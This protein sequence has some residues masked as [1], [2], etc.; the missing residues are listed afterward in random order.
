MKIKTQKGF[1]EPYDMQRIV[2]SLESDV[3]FA[4]TQGVL[5]DLDGSHIRRIARRVTTKLDKM[6]YEDND[7]IS[8]DTIRGLTVSELMADGEDQVANVVGL[9]GLHPKRIFEIINGAADND[10]ANLQHNPETTHKIIAD[11]VSKKYYLGQ[12]PREM[13]RLHLAGDLHIHDLEYFG[14]RLFCQDW[15]LRYFFYYGLM[16]DGEGTRASVSGPAKNPEVAIL[17]AVKA[18]SAAQT[19]FA[20]GQGFYNFLTF[21]APYLEGLSY[22]EIYQL[23]QMFVYEMTQMMVARG[24]QVVFSSVQLTPGVPV[25][26]RDK[27]AVFKGKVWSDRTYGEFE[28]EVRLAFKALMEVMIAGDYWG[29]PFNFPKPEIAIEPEFIDPA[30][31]ED[32]PAIDWRERSTVGLDCLPSYR[33]LYGLAFELTAKFGTPYFDNMIPAYRGHSKGGVACY[34]SIPGD[35]LVATKSIDGIKLEH[36]EDVSDNDMLLT[37]TGFET[38]ESMLKYE[39]DRDILQL[40]LLNGRLI[41]CTPEHEMPVVRNGESIRL[42]ACDI[43]KGD[44]LKVF[45]SLPNTGGLPRH[46]KSILGDNHD[47]KLAYF[48][49]LYTA[50]GNILIRDSKIGG[51]RVQ[52][53]F[54]EENLAQ[55]TEKLIRDLFGWNVRTHHIGGNE[56]RVLAYGKA[57][58]EYLH[59]VLH[60]AEKTGKEG[61]IPDHIFV[62]RDELKW[63]F[64]Q[65]YM[66][67]DGSLGTTENGHGKKYWRYSIETVSRE[68]AEGFLLLTASLGHN[69]SLIDIKTRPNIQLDL[70]READLRKV[71][72][73][74]QGDFDGLLPVSSIST[75]NYTGYVYDPI[76]VENHDFVLGTGL[77]SGNCCAYN[78]QVDPLTDP[79]FADKMQFKNGAH[80]SM[81]SSQVVTLNVPRAA[82]YASEGLT[83][84]SR[85]L[86]FINRLKSLMAE[87]CKVFR[88]KKSLLAPLIAGGRVPFATQR[89]KDPVTGEK[90]TPAADLDAMVWTIGIV[91]MNEAIEVICGK[92]L[93]EDD[94]AVDISRRVMTELK[95]YCYELTAE[96]GFKI[97]LARTPAETVAQRFAVLDLTDDAYHDQ[98]IRVVKGDVTAAIDQFCSGSRDLPIYYTN[99]CMLPSDCDNIY[100]RLTTESKFFPLVDGGN[101]FHIWLGEANTDP[102]ALMDF[103][104][105]VATKTDIG[106]FAFTKDLTVCRTCGTSQCGLH[107][108]CGRCHSDAVDYISRITGYLSSVSGWNAAKRQELEDRR[109]VSI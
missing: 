4:K 99:G 56:Y 87:A 34:Q 100:Q 27:P 92:Q 22:P 60:L 24:G 6:L 17:H 57:L 67:G 38:F 97:A 21:L 58:C 14:T 29:K 63:A 43:Q 25:L 30:T 36:I 106:Y 105:R 8:S 65:G 37:P 74:Q 5:T 62:A 28:R 75:E 55:R 93:H 2:E 31:W 69:F 20:G 98:A 89:P 66:Q 39:T 68:L 10:N 53:S 71:L 40:K 16:P 73:C 64:I 76:N 45:T 1:I 50:E 91:G 83:T 84:E 88:F 108:R 54:G 3:D 51:H 90:G 52:I 61:K 78:F 72:S 46:P 12:M 23:M 96:Y 94:Y 70:G 82:Y 79:D 77:I 9:V 101:I 80:F 47:I 107:D 26:W 19:N 95:L 49:G 48:M 11:E 18:L 33:D 86:I 7:V 41:R 102:G 59:D 15:D 13:S 109:R 35:T 85:T 42:K 103:A 81:G 32:R 44:M 104:M